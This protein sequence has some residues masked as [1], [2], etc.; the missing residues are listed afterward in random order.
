PREPVAPHKITGRTCH[1][2]VYPE[3]GCGINAVAETAPGCARAWSPSTRVRPFSNGSTYGCRS[4]AKSRQ[5]RSWLPSKE[6]PGIKVV[7]G[8]G[9]ARGLCRERGI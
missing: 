4:P 6:F 3:Y 1:C 2:P 5:R 8:V 7:K 9:Q